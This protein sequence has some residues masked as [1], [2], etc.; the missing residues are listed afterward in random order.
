M[1][2][3]VSWKSKP[4]ERPWLFGAPMFGGWMFSFTSGLKCTYLAWNNVYQRQAVIPE[5]LLFSRDDLLQAQPTL[6]CLLLV[7]CSKTLDLLWWSYCRREGRLGLCSQF[8]L[9]WRVS[10]L[11]SARLQGKQGTRAKLKAVAALFAHFPKVDYCISI[12]LDERSDN[13]TTQTFTRLY[14]DLCRSL[15]WCHKG[16]SRPWSSMSAWMEQMQIPWLS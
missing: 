11:R 4:C 9:G 16:T 5:V 2:W 3:H 7:C 13:H 8:S 12:N 15:F 6:C 10:C 14:I 1:W